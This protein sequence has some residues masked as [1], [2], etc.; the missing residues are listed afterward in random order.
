MYGVPTLRRKPDFCFGGASVLGAHQLNGRN[1]ILELRVDSFPGLRLK[2]MKH[3]L[4][5][6]HHY[7]D[8]GL[9]ES[10][11]RLFFQPL[12]FSSVCGAR[13]SGKFTPW[14]AANA[15]SRD[16]DLVWSVTIVCT[17]CLISGLP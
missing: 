8:V 17:N 15:L 13:L 6:C 16:V 14:S 10:G 12:D 7:L 11:P 3:L 9:I 2:G 1:K 4:V 5:I